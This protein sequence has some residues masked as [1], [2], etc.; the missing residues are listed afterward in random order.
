MR[1]KKFF[2]NEI[3]DISGDRTNDI[4]EDLQQM[5]TFLNQ[6][7]ENIDSYINELGNFQNKTKSKNDQID[8]SVSNLQLVRGSLIDAYDKL[9][10]IILSLE[11]YN[12]SGRKYI[13]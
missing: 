2:E 9:D 6:K 12:K 13:Y 5:V 4:I 1:I 8:D 11:D 3:P 10:N 7:V